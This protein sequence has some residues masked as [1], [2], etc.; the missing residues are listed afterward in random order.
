M[1]SIP[2]LINMKP[3]F[4]TIVLLP[5]ILFSTLLKLKSEFECPAKNNQNV[6]KE[7]C[8]LLDMSYNNNLCKYMYVFPDISSK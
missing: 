6:D 2:K 8:I 4:N 3:L 5:F 1:E 7:N